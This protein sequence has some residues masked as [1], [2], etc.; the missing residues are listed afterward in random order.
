M[1]RIPTIQRGYIERPT[2][3]PEATSAPFR[4]MA[5]MGQAISGVGN[6]ILETYTTLEQKRKAAL[7][8]LNLS[9]AQNGLR[10]DERLLAEEFGK[11]T[12]PNE[13]R[14]DDI[15]EKL[16]ASREKY[17]DLFKDD[18]E[19]AQEL[20]NLYGVFSNNLLD[21]VTKKRDTLIT[22]QGKI[23]TNT[24]IE[25]ALN[26]YSNTDNPEQLK[27][28][29]ENIYGYLNAKVRD[30]ILPA[31]Y[32]EE[33]KK[34]FDKNS[35]S[36][37]ADVLIDN[38]PTLA[39]ERLTKGEFDLPPD[40]IKDKIDKAQ[41]RQ[42]QTENELKILQNQLEQEGKQAQQLEHDDEYREI[43]DLYLKRDF[44]GAMKRVNSSDLLTG[45]EKISINKNIEDA[46]KE[47][48]P[49]KNTDYTYYNE[50]L[51]KAQ[52]GE[53]DPNGIIPIPN[54]LSE[55]DAQEIRETAKRALEPKEKISLEMEN[56][57]LTSVQARVKE[58]S[59]FFGYTSESE[60][61]SYKAWAAAKQLLDATEDPQKRISM[62]T[63]GDPAY[64]GDKVV[65]PYIKDKNNLSNAQEFLDMLR[66]VDTKP[67]VQGEEEYSVTIVNP[68][69]K[70]RKGWNGKEW[71]TIPKK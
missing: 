61:N 50:L 51:K 13:I 23:E 17:S 21:V 6:N 26:D 63:P 14:D 24:Y 16:E 71:I 4:A 15:R 18:P 40:V 66:G 67:Q 53:V 37:R 36:L 68:Q 1:P 34:S 19:G 44:V 56:K 8:N 25:N 27:T 7:R 60:D 48:D 65:T 43:A 54:K 32:A 58:G 59:S 38:N 5:G 64:I 29:R 69:T 30:N 3:S 47:T 70:E 2:M 20:E 46:V 35:E 39:I 45:P 28:I 31:L 55:T 42:K 52:K 22:D 10:E 62:M 33:I 12:D 9:K 41:A 11:F 57:L 49:F